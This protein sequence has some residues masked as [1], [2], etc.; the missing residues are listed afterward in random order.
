MVP[1]M[2]PRCP[3]CKDIH[4]NGSARDAAYRESLLQD[5]ENQS[6]EQTNK[7]YALTGALKD[8]EIRILKL[9]PGSQQMPLVGHL[10]AAALADNEGIF[11][12]TDQ[13][14]VQYTA[15]SY[16]WGEDRTSR[17]PIECNSL[18]CALSLE[19][20]RALHRVRHAFNPVYVWIDSLC[21]NQID[22]REKAKQVAMM[23]RI[24]QGARQVSVYL[25]QSRD[26]RS[27]PSHTR[28]DAVTFLLELA[29]D[30]YLAPKHYAASPRIEH[31]NSQPEFRIDAMSDSG[32]FCDDH[33]AFLE[34][35]LH[36]LASLSWFRR[37]WIKQEIWAACSV[38]VHYGGLTIPWGA[39]KA[40][41]EVYPSILEPHVPPGLRHS[42][43]KLTSKLR[44]Y[45][46][47]LNQATTEARLVA[48]GSDASNP[49]LDSENGMDFVDVHHAA[50]VG[51]AEC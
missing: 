37:M 5:P 32:E 48:R 35:G 34:K 12:G 16:F 7:L 9:L 1:A 13:A 47:P 41:Q 23:C 49:F 15:I 45:V 17:L 30:F 28:R 20:Y 44:K 51:L 40:F 25:G 18:A 31:L 26:L 27:T 19:A 50:N 43:S 39:L 21:I 4:A 22:N 42:L 14:H 46:R 3:F 10:H 33:V 36:D 8:N 38:R 24:Y 29:H 2:T 11:I 6:S